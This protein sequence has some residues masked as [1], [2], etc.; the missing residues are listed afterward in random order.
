VSAADGGDRNAV[1][2]Q[3]RQSFVL[4]TPANHNSKL[5][6]DSLGDVG[7]VEPANL[8]ATGKQPVFSE[9]VN[10]YRAMK[11]DSRSG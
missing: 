2:A 6:L 10:E 7:H 1:V 3:I 9:L 11:G 8:N 5:V 4:Q